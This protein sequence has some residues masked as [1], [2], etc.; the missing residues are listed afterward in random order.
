MNCLYVG[1]YFERFSIAIYSTKPKF[2]D[3]SNIIYSF[4]EL[5][6]YAKCSFLFYSVNK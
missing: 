2:R 1:G 5:A 3:H 6:K 4:S